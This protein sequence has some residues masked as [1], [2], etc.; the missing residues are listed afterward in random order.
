MKKNGFSDRLKALID[1]NDLTL[2]QIANAIGTTPTSVHRWTKG[3]EIEYENLLALAKYLGVN[4]IW[5]RYGDEAILTASGAIRD[6]QTESNLRREY[7]D[8]IMANEAR[9]KT[10]LEMAQIVNW[11]WNTITGT[12]TFSANAE[13]VFGYQPEE[14]ISAFAPFASLPLEALKPLF[15]DEQSHQWDFKVAIGNEDRWFASRAK[16]VM[17]YQGVPIRVI[18]VTTNIT[19]RKNAEFALERSEYTQ[20]KIIETIPVGLWAAD[21]QGVINLANPE[22]VR[23]W[24]GAKYVDLDNYGLYKGTWEKNGEPLTKDDWTLARAVTTGEVSNAEV[25]NI[26]GFD[27]VPRTIIMYATPLHNND[28]KIIGAIE[29]NQDITDLKNTE[30]RLRR[31]HQQLQLIYEQDSFGIADFDES[32]I[33]RINKKLTSLLKIK[34]KDVPGLQLVDIFCEKTVQEITE[35]NA[36]GQ[37]RSIQGNLL[38]KGK[39]GVKEREVEIQV[40]GSLTSDSNTSMLLV[41]V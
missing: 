26:E 31:S 8:Q 28:G 18:G 7:L 22:V 25:V 27:G 36:N 2:A 34:E 14:I 32:G 38:I 21:E 13:D 5:L 23:I 16:L 4:W 41:F 17:D 19:Q 9:M 37:A 39:D 3:G 24:G 29:V 1:Q 10:A 20:R 12:F 6:S 11:E 33:K 15:D 35:I 30:R 40:I